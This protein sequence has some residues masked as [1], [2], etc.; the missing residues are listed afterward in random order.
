MFACVFEGLLLVIAGAAGWF[1]GVDP[2]ATVTRDVVPVI[3][4][5]VAVVPMLAMLW[6]GLK[7]PF[8]AVGKATLQAREFVIQF[9]GGVSLTGFALIS[10]LAGVGEEALF[11]GFLQTFIGLHSTELTGLILASLL[12]GLAHAV[13]RTYA[14]IAAIIGVYL[15]LLYI[16]T[17]SIIAPIVCHAVYDFV[18][19]VILSRSTSTPGQGQ[20]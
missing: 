14:L 2:L 5:L 20:R 3:V 15:G 12:F 6:W 11:R 18:A 8:G 13:S 19:L 1:A 16:G 17:G 7:H 4:G 10:L 9:L